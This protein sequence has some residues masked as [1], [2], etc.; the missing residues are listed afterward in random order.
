MTPSV[1]RSG[2]GPVASRFPL[3][4]W[5][6]RLQPW[7]S[8]SAAATWTYTKLYYFTGSNDR[9]ARSPMIAPFAC[10][11]PGVIKCDPACNALLRRHGARRRP[12]SV[13]VEGGA[14]PQGREVG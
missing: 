14:R 13:R 10:M 1:S 6:H 9:T 12:L 3:I 11:H 7:N 8:H 5:A 2:T 4:G